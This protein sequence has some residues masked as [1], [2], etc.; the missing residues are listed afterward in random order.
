MSR[1]GGLLFLTFRESALLLTYNEAKG[2]KS[3]ADCEQPKRRTE[4]IDTLDNSKGDST[5]GL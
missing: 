5:R 1:W 3:K 4:L 2:D